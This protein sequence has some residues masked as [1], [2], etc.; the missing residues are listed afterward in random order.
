MFWLLGLTITIH[1]SLFITYSIYQG[2]T[3]GY[4]E[5]VGGVLREIVKFLYSAVRLRVARSLAQET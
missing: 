3:F 2:L 4:L 1:H 5:D